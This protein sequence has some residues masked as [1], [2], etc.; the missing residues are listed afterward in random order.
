MSSATGEAEEAGEEPERDQVAEV[1]ETDGKVNGTGLS[2]A[3]G[4]RDL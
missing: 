3:P 4:E 2:L 1:A